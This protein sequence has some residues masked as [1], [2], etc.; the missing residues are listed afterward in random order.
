MTPAVAAR[1]ALGGG[2]AAPCL[3]RAGRHLERRTGRGTTR[4]RSRRGTSTAHRRAGTTPIEDATVHLVSAQA[5]CDARRV[6]VM[7]EALTYGM[8]GCKPPAAQHVD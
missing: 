3:S 8:I 4:R 2:A 1:S 5:P 6:L 7:G